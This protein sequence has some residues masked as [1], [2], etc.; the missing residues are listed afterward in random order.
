MD[1]IL[2]EEQEMMRRMVGLAREEIAP[3]VQQMEENDEFPLQL[4]RKMGEYG[5]MGIPIPEEW[6]GSGADF[7]SY[8]IAI[9]EIAK[10]SPTVGVILSVHTSVGTNPA[11]TR[12]RSQPLAASARD[13]LVLGGSP[14]SA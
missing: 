6:G 7:L 1:L 11:K 14:F 12:V 8:I 5:L 9:H 2:T 4:I 3:V 10:V 13:G